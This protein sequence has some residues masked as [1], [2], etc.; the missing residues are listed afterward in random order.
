VLAIADR[1]NLADQ[2]VPPRPC[3]EPCPDNPSQY[4]V[5]PV[6]HDGDH[7]YDE[8]GDLDGMAPPPTRAMN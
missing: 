2:D 7:L 4:C 8:L 5:A 6:G 3:S 1:Q